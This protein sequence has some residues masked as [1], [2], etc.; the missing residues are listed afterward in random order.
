MTGDERQDHGSSRA[1][2]DE[3]RRECGRKWAS[4]QSFLCQAVILPGVN[5]CLA[6]ASAEDRRKFLASL[7]GDGRIGRELQNLE[8]SPDLLGEL[9]PYLGRFPVDFSGATFT[10]DADFKG[11]HF[12][13]DAIFREANFT[14]EAVF[15][16]VVLPKGADFSQATFQKGIDLSTTTDGERS[17]VVDLQG[18][19]FITAARIDLGRPLKLNDVVVQDPL[20]I[21]TSSGIGGYAGGKYGHGGPEILS[22]ERVTLE[23]PLVVGNGVPLRRC[24][25]CGATGL[26][27]LRILSDPL[28]IRY[29]GRWKRLTKAHHWY[30]R[31]RPGFPKE[32]D[33]SFFFR[34]TGGRRVLAEELQWRSFRGEKTAFR[35][36]QDNDINA[37]EIPFAGSW[38]SP[39]EIEAVYRQLRAALE[40][41]KAAPAA[42]DFYYGEMEMRRLGARDAGLLLERILLRLYKVTAGYGLRAYR[43][44]ATYALILLA[45]SALFYI[46]TATFVSDTAAAAGGTTPTA[47]ATGTPIG[48]PSG[49]SSSPSTN[50]GAPAARLLSFHHFGDVAAILGRSSVSFLSPI[51]NGLTALG[52][53]MIILLRFSAPAA[54][55]L[56]VLAVRARVQR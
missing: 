19:R 30:V 14:G 12:V 38:P 54:L 39:P 42:A 13:G 10:G 4:D 32:G 2:G 52:T 46:R 34:I 48:S 21:V 41:S 11:A 27:R 35:L 29:A 26:E 47:V 37:T 25:L 49:P 22:L 45:F 1:V 51:P 3:H 28:W 17:G 8:V 44:L 40:A 50:S 15:G 5:G 9:R 7:D 20:T 23:A 33:F 43:A 55:A 16:G 36:A 24:L 53:L 18:A 6:H 56:A 31:Y